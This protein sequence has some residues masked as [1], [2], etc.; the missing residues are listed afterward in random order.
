MALIAKRPFLVIANHNLLARLTEYQKFFDN[1]RVI[2]I[3]D[4]VIVNASVLDRLLSD[5]SDIDYN[6]LN[7]FVNFSREWYSTALR[8][9]IALTQ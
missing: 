9:A 4:G 1:Q 5:K 8:G 2:N 7:Y 3:L 6:A